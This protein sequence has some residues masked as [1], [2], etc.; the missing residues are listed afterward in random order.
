MK[1]QPKLLLVPL[2]FILLLTLFQKF[3]NEKF[4]EMPIPNAKMQVGEEEDPNGRWEFE[5][6]RTRDPQTNEIPRNIRLKEIDFVK[7]IPNRNQVSMKNVQGGASSLKTLNWDRRGPYNVGGRTRAMA[8][9]ATNESIIIAGGVSGGMWKSVDG[10]ATW[11]KTTKPEQLHSVTAVAQDTRS[12][13][14]STWYFGSG[15]YIGNSA[16]GSGAPFRGNGI[17]KSTDGGDSWTSLTSTASNTPQSYDNVFD[18]VNNVI[19]NPLNGYVFISGVYGLRRSMD[20]GNTWS[21]LLGS[22]ALNAYFTEISI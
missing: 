2:F 7:N 8:L 6:L 14:T 10:G 4:Y 5:W 18:Y 17:Y 3:N 9:D 12:G 1:Y 21:A 13:H 16:G 15:E 22:E 11:K 20:G 19:V